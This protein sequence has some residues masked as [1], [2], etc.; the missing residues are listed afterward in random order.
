KLSLVS[1]RYPNNTN[2][3]ITNTTTTNRDVVVDFK[4]LKEEGEEKMQALRE[5]LLNLNIKESFI[6]KILKE[7]PPS[8]IE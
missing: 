8:K 1:K 6:E 7:Y 2:L 4:K 3:N 5:Q